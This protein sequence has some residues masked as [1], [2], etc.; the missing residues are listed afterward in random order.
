[1]QIGVMFMECK[2]NTKRLSLKMIKKFM[3]IMRQRNREREKEKER[4][5]DKINFKCKHPF[6]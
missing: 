3:E 1:M 2:T 5:R 6:F 4:E